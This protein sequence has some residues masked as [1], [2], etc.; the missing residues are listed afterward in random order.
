MASEEID[1]SPLNLCGSFIFGQRYEMLINFI[2]AS[3]VSGAVR[4]VA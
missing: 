2:P 1:F 4:K 3:F